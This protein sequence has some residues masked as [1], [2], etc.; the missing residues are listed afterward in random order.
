MFAPSL[1]TMNAFATSPEQIAMV[2]RGVIIAGA[3]AAL[4]GV[5]VSMVSESWLPF[6]FSV[7]G[8]GL[9]AAIYEHTI[10][11]GSGRGAIREQPAYA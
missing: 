6:W 4:I 11:T 3:F 5:A 1:M 7:I 2:R 9:T 8:W 10:Q